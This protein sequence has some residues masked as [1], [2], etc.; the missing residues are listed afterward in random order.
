M[1]TTSIDACLSAVA[2]TPV[3]ARSIAGTFGRVDAA[4]A[5]VTDVSCARVSVVT[6]TVTDTFWIV[7]ANGIFTEVGCTEVSI[8]ALLVRRTRRDINTTSLSIAILTVV[9]L[10][11]CG[12]LGSVD[13]SVFATRIRGAGVAVIAVVLA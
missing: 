5:I 1:L 4:A 3:A 9:A 13:A 6:F 2:E 10:S 12:A 8:I 7:E 11:I